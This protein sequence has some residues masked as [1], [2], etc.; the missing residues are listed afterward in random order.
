MRRRLTRLRAADGMGLIELLAAMALL[1]I[2]IS[3]L[4]AAFASSV[5]SVS[6]AGAEGTALTLADRQMEVYRALPYECVALIQPAGC[7]T[8]TGFPNP[9]SGTQTVAAADSPDHR[10]YTVTTSITAEGSDQ[11]KVVITVTNAAGSELAHESSLFSALGFPVTTT[12][13]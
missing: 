10:E 8:K 7:P 11:R 3:A 13:P 1:G 6:H 9:Y 5:L 2:A 12:T 4:L